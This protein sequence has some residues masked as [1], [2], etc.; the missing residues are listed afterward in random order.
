MW[1][2]LS[3]GG[4]SARHWLWEA[5]PWG[6]AN[7]FLVDGRVLQISERD[8][9]LLWSE[10]WSVLEKELRTKRVIISAYPVLVGGYGLARIESIVDV[11]G[12][13]LVSK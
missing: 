12:I 6:A 1:Q 3:L 11:D 5:W 8:D 13:P 2:L 9:A 7:L 10:P 4:G